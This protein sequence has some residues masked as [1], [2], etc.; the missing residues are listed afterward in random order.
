MVQQQY[1]TVIVNDTTVVELSKGLFSFVHRCF[2][3][4]CTLSHYMCFG[5]RTE[6]DGFHA[7]GIFAFA[8]FS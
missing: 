7:G 5:Y 8:S 1:E 4:F 6:H 2:F 3:G